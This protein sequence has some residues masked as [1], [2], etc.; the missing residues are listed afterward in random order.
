M[1]VPPAGLD[2]AVYDVIEAPP[3]LAGAV[4]VTVAVV[5]DTTVAVPIIGAPGAAG[6]NPDSVRELSIPNLGM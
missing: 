4:N 3:L 2:V 6:N 1:P 5:E